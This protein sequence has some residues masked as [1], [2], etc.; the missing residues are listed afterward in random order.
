MRVALRSEAPE[1]LPAAA[2]DASLATGVD[3]GIKSDRLGAVRIGIDGAPGDLRVSLGLS[4]AAAALVAADAPRLIADLAANGVRLQSLDVSGG[5]FAGGQAPS[6][7]Q[8]QP[9]S[10]APMVPRA[11]VPAALAAVNPAIVVRTST[12]DRY[13]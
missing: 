7:G 1:Q 2:P 5:G 4:P 13:A 9:Q 3:I 8:Q 12:A 6:P 10:P 11:A